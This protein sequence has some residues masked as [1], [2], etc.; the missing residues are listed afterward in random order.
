MIDGSRTT[1]EW[2]M[3]TGDICILPVGSFEQHS[4]HLPL[5]TDNIQADFFAR[6][7]AEEF[8]AAML[9]TLPLGT[10]MEHSGFRGSITLRPETMMQMIRDI[11]DEVERQGFKVLIVVN[12]HGGNFA[13]APA[14]RDINR[15]DRPL[16]VL[17]VQT[18][19]F[20]SPD[21]ATESRE[22]GLDI[23]AGETETSVMLA[24]RPEAVR[25]FSVDA[26]SLQEKGEAIPLRQS[27]LNTFGAGHFSSAGVIG[28]PSFASAEKGHA[29]IAAVRARMLPYLH[30]RIARLKQQPRYAGSGGIALRP[31]TDADIADGMRLKTLAG[32]NQTEDDWHIFHRAGP[33][34]CF[35][36]VHNGHVIGTVA[37]IPYGDAL[38]W[39][40]MVLV[41]PQFRR[42]GIGTRLLE[43]ALR[44]LDGCPTVKLDAT[45][46]GKEVYDR[47][48]FV[49]EY[50]LQRW[51]HPYVPLLPETVSADVLSITEDSLTRIIEWDSRVFGA[52]RG[53]LLRALLKS[54]P[55][56]ACY[57]ER[58]GQVQGYCL[59]R[60]GSAFQQIGPVV[61]ETS[62]TAVTLLH[63]ALKY[64][65]GHA[66]VL[67]VPDRQHELIEWLRTH[68][69]VSQRLFVRMF[70]GTNE[71][72]GLP[73]RQFA[74][75]GP[76]FG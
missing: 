66:V 32:W 56:S 68:G 54:S 9:P 49:E 22:H 40:G 37:T 30:D 47:L 18:W 72:P 28:Y 69:F 48:G 39:I 60:R 1:F 21:I 52:D 45:P 36:A 63:A 23:H 50:T 29:I 8:N 65:G 43:E 74:I 19:E 4:H 17:L 57:L 7:V 75:V 25:A 58:E 35:A 13:L 33:N 10:C 14:I 34:N 53:F 76:E 70:R 24:I 44:H 59:G 26:P 15:L 12:G 3:H 27:D 42:M 71:S 62:E 64:F 67:D 2:Q 41:D 55:A 38:A 61:A 51:I 16:K 20:R 6:L 31:M 11:A 46:A 73:D 5:E